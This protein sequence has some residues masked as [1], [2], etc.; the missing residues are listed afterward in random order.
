MGASSQA[1]ELKRHIGKKIRIEK[2]GLSYE[3]ELKGL[4][5]V[6]VADKFGT[7][8]RPWLLDTGTTEIHFAADDGWVVKPS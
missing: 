7:P 2:F 6:I 3:G 5:H 4:S 8:A 1:E